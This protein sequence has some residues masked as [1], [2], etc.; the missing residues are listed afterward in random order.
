MGNGDI[1]HADLTIARTPVL[2]RSFLQ[3]LR[4]LPKPPKGA[5]VAVL[6]AWHDA[7]LEI[8]RERAQQ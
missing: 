3:H 7:R 5:T 4:S 2:W 6:R 1:E 8:E